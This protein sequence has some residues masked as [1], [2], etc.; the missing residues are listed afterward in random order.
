MEIK[1][2]FPKR[3]TP[4]PVMDAILQV[5][6]STSPLTKDELIRLTGKT[7]TQI[8]SAIADLIAN[9]EIKHSDDG[10]GYVLYLY[11]R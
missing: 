2:S 3:K 1:G 8:S 9:G 4:R 5:L 7:R 6:S 10:K 11:F